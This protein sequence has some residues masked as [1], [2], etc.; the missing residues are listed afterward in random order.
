MSTTLVVYIFYISLGGMIVLL[1]YK[2][3][4]ICKG[5]HAKKSGVNEHEFFTNTCL[6]VSDK[7]CILL[8]SG[9]KHFSPLLVCVKRNII[10][11]HRGFTRFIDDINFRENKPGTIVENNGVASTYLKNILAQKKSI[12]KKNSKV[13][14]SENL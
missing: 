9:K 3:F 5:H 8:V 10:L 4:M 12:Q 6:L 13:F 14:H 2:M 7:I 1:S 11:T